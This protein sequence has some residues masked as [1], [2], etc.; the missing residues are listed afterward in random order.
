MIIKHNAIISES[1][2]SFWLFVSDAPWCGHCKALAPEYVKAAAHLKEEG[3]EIRLGK[4]DATV[5]NTIA[6]KYE[7]RGYPT[8]KF[9]R[10]GKAIDY[11]GE[12]PINEIN[13]LWSSSSAD[14]EVAAVTV[15]S[16]RSA[17]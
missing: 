17:I 10:N 8:I 16:N 15:W 7:V 1:V 6:E 9:L 12:P 2:F 14:S 3:S 4:V 11:Q 5:E 13:E